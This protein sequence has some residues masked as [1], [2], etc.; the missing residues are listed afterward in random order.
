LAKTESD[1]VREALLLEELVTV[2][3]KRDELVTHWDD[4]ERA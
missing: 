4:Q 1:R 3:N 2:V